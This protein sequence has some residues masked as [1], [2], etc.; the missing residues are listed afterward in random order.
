MIDYLDDFYQARLQALQAVD[1][2]IDGLFQ[3]LE[4]Y[5]MLNNTYVIYSSDNGYHIANHRLL[6]GKSTSFEEDIH[7]PLIIRG[8]GVPE[9]HTTSLVTTHTDLAPTFF[10]L[11]GVPLRPEFDGKPIPVTK[12]GLDTAL[13]EKHEHVNIEYWGFAGG[14]GIYDCITLIEHPKSIPLT[15]YSDPSLIKNN[16]YKA[17]RIIAEDYDLYYSVWCNNEHE[18]YDMRVCDPAMSRRCD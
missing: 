13:R 4:F 9:N 12:S 18:L 2:L 3:R 16:T 5:G 14:E 6:A 11:L 17:L 10:S 1:E 7:V 15:S 8:P